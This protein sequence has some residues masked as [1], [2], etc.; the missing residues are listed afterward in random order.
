MCLQC[1]RSRFDVWVGKIPRRRKC[2][3]LQ[4]SCP[5]NSLDRGAP[6]ATDQ[7]I[8]RVRHGLATKSSS[9]IEHAIGVK[10]LVDNKRGRVAF[11]DQR[12]ARCQTDIWEDLMWKLL[13]RQEYWS[14]EP[15]PPV[16][17]LPDPGIEPGSPGLQADSLLSEP[18][19]KTWMKYTCEPCECEERHSRPREKHVLRPLSSG[20]CHS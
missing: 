15:F 19:G 4:Y 18:P 10:G 17:D 2:N 9:M 8:A 1:R 5:E 3:P 20:I 7:G 12:R 13:S 14:G 16:G 11:N 6:W